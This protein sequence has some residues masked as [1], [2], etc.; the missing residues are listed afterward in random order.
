M[1]QS[2][3]SQFVKSDE[4]VTAAAL[5]KTLL[6]ALISDAP[7]DTSSEQERAK[8]MAAAS[9]RSKSGMVEKSKK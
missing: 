4:G 9:Q 1:T 2:I 5:G 8:K 7:S 6:L 3:K